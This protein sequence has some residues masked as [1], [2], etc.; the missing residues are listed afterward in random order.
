MFDLIDDV[1]LFKT[2]RSQNEDPD[3]LVPVG[4]KE[5]VGFVSDQVRKAMLE[6]KIK[7]Q[8]QIQIKSNLKTPNDAIFGGGYT[9]KDGKTVVGAAHGIE[10]MLKMAEKKN[11]K[12]YTDSGELPEEEVKQKQY[13]QQLRHEMQTGKLKSVSSLE[14]GD[15]RTNNKSNNAP[16]IVDL[17]DFGNCHDEP[18]PIT[19]PAPEKEPEIVRSPSLPYPSSREETYI[20]PEKESD[21]YIQN[22]PSREDILGL[23]STRQ[24]IP[25][26]TP[27]KSLGEDLLNLTTTTPTN[28]PTI[29]TTNNDV[30]DA[31]T[32]MGNLSLNNDIAPTKPLTPFDTNTFPNH[33][34][35][36][37]TSIMGGMN[38]SNSASAISSL[39]ILPPMG[40]VAT[41]LGGIVG[42]SNDVIGSNEE[43][44]PVSPVESPPPLPSTIPS[45][46]STS[47]PPPEPRSSPRSSPTPMGGFPTH[48][49]TPSPMVGGESHQQLSSTPMGGMAQPQPSFGFNNSTGTSDLVESTNSIPG[50]NANNSSVNSMNAMNQQQEMMMMMMNQQQMMMQ[51][52]INGGNDGGNAQQAQ[53]MQ[54]MMMMN[55]Q[56]MQQLMSMQSQM[57]Q[58]NTNGNPSPQQSHPVQT[59]ES[60]Y[61]SS[62]NP[63]G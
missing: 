16:P 21:N 33:G 13:V 44:R 27:V 58:Q 52:G 7:K 32:A 30:H 53:M 50:T 40:G 22:Q 47:P 17:L 55:Q 1:Q 42:S 63:F 26:P 2:V 14:D 37:N 35:S 11:A 31:F 5:E 54:Q 56:M 24:S 23:K 25:Q 18:Q 10:E 20:L 15:E 43:H 45:M 61:P 8:S 9:S 38:H 12:R 62:R 59:R 49:S 3:S 34:S 39:D 6:E 29:S 28:I 60:E 19:I 51:Q 4:D 46:P 36:I 48:K 41:G 57:G